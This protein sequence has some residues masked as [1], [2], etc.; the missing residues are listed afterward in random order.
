[1]PPYRVIV[2]ASIAVTMKY[3]VAAAWVSLMRAPTG[4]VPD[5]S[6]PVVQT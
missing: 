2:V 3:L 1:M 4:M 5:R 6:L